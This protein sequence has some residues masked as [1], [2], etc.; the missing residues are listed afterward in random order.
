MQ[1]SVTYTML[2]KLICNGRYC[3]E[4]K[5]RMSWARRAEVQGLKGREAWVGILGRSDPHSYHAVGN[6][7]E[8]WSSQCMVSEAKLRPS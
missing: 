2:R 4:Q 7:M 6:L 8:H 3:E 1:F 5:T